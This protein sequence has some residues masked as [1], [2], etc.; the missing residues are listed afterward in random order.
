[1]N[2]AERSSPMRLAGWAGVGSVLLVSP[3]LV[4]FLQ[5]PQFL[6]HEVSPAAILSGWPL[7][8]IVF[9]VPFIVGLGIS[10]VAGQKLRNGMKKGVWTDA[11]LEP[12]RRGLRN[13]VLVLI[14]TALLVLGFGLVVTSRGFDHA[15]Y[16]AFLIMPFQIWSQIAQAV[17]PVDGSKE[18]IDWN[19][20]ATIRSEH[21]GEPPSGT[22]G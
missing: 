3:A 22:V 1:M 17:R 2:Y 12:L 18:R 8:L 9:G 15:G 4:E 14:A 21:W 6:A 20:S 11:E 13:P 7:R 16:F 10:L 19:G 5:L